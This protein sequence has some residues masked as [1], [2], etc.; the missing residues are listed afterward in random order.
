MS[1]F[2]E[3]KKLYD[4]GKN[5]STYLKENPDVVSKYGF[6]AS[7]AIAISYDLQAG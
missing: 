2:G 4:D 7:D 1:V 5:I 6:S 3:L